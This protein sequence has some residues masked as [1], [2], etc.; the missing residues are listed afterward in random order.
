M[1]ELFSLPFNQ[2]TH[3]SIQSVIQQPMHQF[4]Q[5]SSNPS[6]NSVIQQP[7]HKFSHPATHPP[8][9]SVIQQPIHQFSQSSSNTLCP[10]YSFKHHIRNRTQERNKLR[11][12]VSSGLSPLIFPDEAKVLTAV[13][14]PCMIIRGFHS[15]VWPCMHAR[16]GEGALGAA[17]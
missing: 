15:A 8:I 17:A 13:I 3:P 12:S 14:M 2:A 9:Q 6:T 5:S 4:S 7:I 1:N 11:N 16:E 10:F